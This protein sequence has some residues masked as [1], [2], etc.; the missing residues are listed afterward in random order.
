[1]VW[2]I[3][4][5]KN[6]RNQRDCW[7]ET[8]IPGKRV[9]REN[10]PYTL[11]ILYFYDF[12]YTFIIISVF[13]SILNVHLLWFNFLTSWNTLC[14]ILRGLK[15]HQGLIKPINHSI[16]LSLSL[17]RFVALSHS[18]WT[19]RLLCVHFLFADRGPRGFPKFL[20]PE[21]ENETIYLGE[22]SAPAVFLPWLS[23]GT[24]GICLWLTWGGLRVI[25]V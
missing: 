18:R 6:L 1:M 22:L 20:R 19:I 15:L 8:R 21:S 17:S 13:F 23:I 14:C 10:H 11:I 25:T 9:I 24:T 3:L 5:K 4:F 12:M 7:K 16:N 2:Y